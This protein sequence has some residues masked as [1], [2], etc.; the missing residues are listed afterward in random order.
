MRSMTKRITSTAHG[1]K[2]RQGRDGEHIVQTNARHL[3]PGTF[4]NRYEALR[5][6]PNRASS[7]RIETA[8]APAPAR[9]INLMR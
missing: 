8:K 7:E 6:L 9:V 5:E 2:A 3:R 1:C 4:E